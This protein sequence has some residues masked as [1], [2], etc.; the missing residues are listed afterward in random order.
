MTATDAFG[1]LQATLRPQSVAVIGA[2]TSPDKLGHEILKNI[3]D[4]GFT[5]AI[6]PVNPKADRILDLPCW[7]GIKEIPEPPDL[8]V[9]IIPARFVPQTLQECGEA[10]VKGAI[11]ITGGFSEAGAEGERLQEEL[12]A[13]CG[14]T[15]IRLIGP[16]C[17]GVNNP[18]HPL[19]ASWPLLTYRGKVAVISQSGTVG[20]AMMDWFSE[21]KLGVSCFVSM[22][23]R[24]DVD[25]ADL[26]SY[27]NQDPH[28]EVIAAYIEGVKRPAQ[29]NS[30][31]EQLRKPLVV[32]KSGRTPR[33]K[34]AAESHTKA[35]AGADAIY[36]ALFKRYNVC[37]AHTIE[38]FYDFAK[39]FAYLTPPKGN[40]ILFVTTSGGAA[41]LAMDQAEQE[42]L[43]AAELP[44][45]L[46]EKITPLVPPHAIKTN[47]IDL[48]GDATAAMFAEVI[49][50]TRHSYDTVGV[51]FGDPVVGASEVVSAGAN[52]LV[53]FLGGA[54]VERAER[55]KMHLA[56]IPVFP[57][58]ERGV[59]ALARVLAANKLAAPSSP[60]LTS[61]VSGRQLPPHLAMSRIAEA[62]LTVT[63]FRLADSPAAA[64]ESARQQGF[65][66]ALKICSADIVH[67]SD[68]GGVHL[69]VNSAEAVEKGFSE[70][71]AA[72]AAAHPHARLEGVMVS[73][74]APAGVEVIIGMRR[75]PQF[76]P[77]ILFG[78]GGILVEIFRDV[79]LRLLPL[80]RQEALNMIKEL[81]GS[82][83]LFGYRGQP[84]VDSNA[85]AD[86]LLTV[87]AIAEKNP[88]ILEIDLNPVLA[89][90]EGYM[91]VDARIIE[92]H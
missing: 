11:I 65:P 85:L 28:T 52:E 71:M 91:V 45:E 54:E 78:L 38:E 34:V 68:V 43:D 55:E 58:P 26:I 80:S 37:R 10:G 48:T 62:G 35:L 66:V 83:V 23:N 84:P 15:G 3:V 87:A 64:V 57:T 16:N 72:A 12:V 19:C 89:Y 47:P 30:A 5:G 73:K 14:Q 49:Q 40:R 88:H 46:A 53:I 67:K 79:S 42:G 44:R 2:S 59:K 9:I 75:D 18:H 51:I 33:G 77:V 81:Q 41:I 60:T 22:G 90:Q 74:M 61:P 17:Q 86:C 8:A 29:F 1:R 70:I 7:A 82:R 92:S 69:N 32:L 24:A 56:G 39:G 25:E 76:G 20:A 27:F 21:E 13:I 6:Y 31:L 4:S 50:A 36:D 63:P